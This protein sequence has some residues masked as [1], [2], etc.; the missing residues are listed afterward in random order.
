M[1]ARILG[2]QAGRNRILSALASGAKATASSFL[3]VFH[4]LWLEVTGFT[5]LCLAVIGGVAGVREYHKFTAGQVTATKVWVA[6]A[7]TTT[8]LYFGISSFWRARK[9]RR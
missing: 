6:V 1:A 5:F 2:Q 9:K 8:F 7:F 4:I 3:K